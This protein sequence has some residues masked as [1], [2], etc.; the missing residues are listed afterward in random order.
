[1]S[2]ESSATLLFSVQ[3]LTTVLL[4]ADNVVVYWLKCSPDL[5]TFNVA[6]IDESSLLNNVLRNQ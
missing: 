3:Q 2:L 1:M 4:M 6:I 5:K